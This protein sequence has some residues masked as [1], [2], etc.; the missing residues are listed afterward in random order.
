MVAD[1]QGGGREG[2]VSAAPQALRPGG[3]DALLFDLGGV[4]IDIDFDRVF[5]RWAEHAR[6]DQASLRG[7]FAQDEAYQRHE[8]G[9]IDAAEYF[10]SLRVSLGIDLTHAQFLDGWNAIFI[11]EVAGIADLLARAAPK[12][13]LY[14]FSNTNRAHE[15]H[16]SKE[17]AGVMRR[18]RK[19][20]VSSAIGL[21]KP[22]LEAFQYVARE[23][24]ARP[25]RIV[26]FDDAPQNI[27]GARTCGL[28]V[29]QVNSVADVAAA[30]AALDL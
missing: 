9:T 4:I 22:D 15:L 16:W 5:A 7:R 30:L 12:I 14:A 3:A 27:E 18:F 19:V 24:G 10:A 2:G 6:C 11:D 1:H 20:F 8:V 21:R 29:V 17:F 26:F 25:E 23:M 13:P 28:Q